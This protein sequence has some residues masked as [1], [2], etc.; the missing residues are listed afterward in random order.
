MALTELEIR[1]ARATEKPIKLFDGDGL[2]LF[3]QPNGGRWWRF[4]YRFNGK[5]RELS[6]GVYPEVSLKLAR[7]RREDARRAVAQGIDPSAERKA[8]KEARQV[9]FE[10]V[11]EEWLALQAKKLA[12]ITYD[13]LAGCS[14]RSS[15]RASD[16]D[17]FPRLPRRNCWERYD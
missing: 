16:R 9:T 3:V 2:Y 15:T 6:L 13:K 14:R 8:A 4:K 5:E 11:A 17:L 7:T 12:P 1:S 10:L